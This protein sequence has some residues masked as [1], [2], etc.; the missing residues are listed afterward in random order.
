HFLPAGTLALLP[1]TRRRMSVVWVETQDEARKLCAAPAEEF[2][3]RLQALAGHRWGRLALLDA[4]HA[5][6][7]SLAIS[8]AFSGK[9]IVLVGDAAHGV[10]P[11]AGQGLNLGLRDV[12]VL[13]DVLREAVINGLD[14]G[15]PAVLRDYEMGCRPAAVAMAGATDGLF[16]LFTNALPPVRILRDA[17]MKAFGASKTLTDYSLLYAAGLQTPM[18]RLFAAANITNP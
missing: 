6:P 7:L 9:R 14:F 17:G 16:D 4:P 12:A 2:V 15:D 5:F 10:H 1:M 18:P 13:A 11:L 8:R 3:L